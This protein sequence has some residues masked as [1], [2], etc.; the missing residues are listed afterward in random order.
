[1][2]VTAYFLF[3][4]LGLTAITT[5]AN[6][7]WTSDIGDAGKAS[8][9]S[10]H[11]RGVQV[12]HYAKAH[13]RGYTGVRWAG[14]SPSCRQAASQGG[15]CGCVAAEKLLGTSAHVVNGVNVWLAN[16]WLAF[17]RMSPA[18]GTAAVWPG[19]HV[20]AVVAVNGDGTVTT[21]G[22]YGMRRVRT[23]GLIFVDPRGITINRRYAAVAHR[24]RWRH[25]HYAGA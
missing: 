7:Y 25:R 20:E 6:A 14:L 9:A 13:R 24:P 3:A 1:M 5:Q 21:D 2:R 4:F 22:P 16:G 12:A 17:P 11:S 18:P 23:A 8:H 19:R 15:P 10:K